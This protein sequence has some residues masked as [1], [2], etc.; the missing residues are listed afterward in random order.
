MSEKIQ[1]G[2]EALYPQVYDPNLLVPIPRAQARSSVMGDKQPPF[3]GVDIWTAY[4]LS[5]LQLGGKP[6][7]AIAEFEISAASACLI[8]SKS[9]KYYLNSLNDRKF[10]GR[11]QVEE[12]LTRDLQAAC[13][14]AVRVSLFALEGAR[15]LHGLPGVCVDSL[16]I[17]ID[18]YTPSP[19]ILSTLS[20]R[21]EREQLY[22]HLLKS[23]CPV[24]GQPDWAS[25]WIEYS[26]RKIRPE[27]FLRYVVSYRHHQDFHESCVEKI[28][29]DISTQCQ[30]EALSVYARYTRRGGLD[31]NP[32]RTDCDRP[33]PSVRLARQ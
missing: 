21:V 9:L 6:E 31:I 7:V 8:E 3:S 4:E 1:L 18:Q 27:A 30:T 14:G 17:A 13:G 28:F 15:Q 29:M 22:S 33:I 16:D 11:E 20:T 2:K 23:N 24:T 12:A 26:G 25:V 32:F 10:A 19:A 5:W